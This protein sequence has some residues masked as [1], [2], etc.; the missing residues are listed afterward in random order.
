MSDQQD[1]E[2]SDEGDEGAGKPADPTPR[3]RRIRAEEAR[4]SDRI[5]DR[6]RLQD[7]IT[8]T[9]VKL[10]GGFLMIYGGPHPIS[11]PRREWIWRLPALPQ[12]EEGGAEPDG[13]PGPASDS[14]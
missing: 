3:P 5:V 13:E 1:Q 8:V 12:S 7:P 11:L 6:D 9:K 10:D 14:G 4:P 2:R